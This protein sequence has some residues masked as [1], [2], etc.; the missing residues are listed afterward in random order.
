[1]IGCM[2]DLPDLWD[3]TLARAGRTT[4]APRA[5]QR[6]G[7]R[8]NSSRGIKRL[9]RKPVV[10][11]GRYTSVD[12]MVSLVRGGVLDLIGAARPRSPT[13]SCRK[14]IE[15]GRIEDIREC[16]G[17]NICVAGDF[18]QS[19]LRCAR[20]ST[21]AEEWR[22]GWHPE[23]VAPQELRRRRAGGRRRTRGPRGRPRARQARVFGDA[24]G[25]AARTRRARARRIAAPGPRGLDPGA[26]LPA[27][28][29]RAGC[30]TCM[31]SSTT[32]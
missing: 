8:R 20:I 15:E 13:R 25:G 26:R 3:V 7:T 6:K 12:R 10:G 2:A 14:K 32:G 4:R 31:C 23:R 16:I 17:R 5:S 27:Q 22:R 9:T 24:R 1:M 21:M 11:V 30:R 18:T 19:P 29:A 28:A